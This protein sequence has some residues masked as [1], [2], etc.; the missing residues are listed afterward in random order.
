MANSVSLTCTDVVSGFPVSGDTGVDWG[1]VSGPQA[2]NTMIITRNRTVCVLDNI[3]TRFCVKCDRSHHR[4]NPL[5]ILQTVYDFYPGLET[6]HGFFKEAREDLVQ[7]KTSQVSRRWSLDP[8]EPHR[9]SW[10][11]V[12]GAGKPVWSGVYD[13]RLMIERQDWG[14]VDPQVRGDRSIGWSCPI[15]SKGINFSRRE[16]SIPGLE[17]I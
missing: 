17:T 12:L 4:S 15:P 16:T 8:G 2:A 10:R 6:S 14:F 1:A 3:I 5:N 7:P 11:C 13:D 9:A